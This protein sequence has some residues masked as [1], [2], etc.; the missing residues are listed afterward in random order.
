MWRIIH[1]CLTEVTTLLLYC[2]KL[3][4]DGTRRVDRI[5]VT[6]LQLLYPLQSSPDAHKTHLLLRKLNQTLDLLGWG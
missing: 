1:S 4:D 6:A 2:T 5:P 3:A